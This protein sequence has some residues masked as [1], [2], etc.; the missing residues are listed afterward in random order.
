MARKPLI[1]E[2]QEGTG[3]IVPVSHKLNHDGYFRK[4]FAD[5]L[6]MYHVYV[7]EQ[8]HGKLPEGYEVHHKCGNRACC[9]IEHLE[10][11][12]GHEHTVL[13][14]HERYLNRYLEAKKYWD[15]THCTG[16]ALGEKFG[17]SFSTGC[18]WIRQW[19]SGCVETIPKG[20]R[21]KGGTPLVPEKRDTVPTIVAGRFVVL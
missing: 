2:E 11:I 1:F 20:S 17:V 12:E 21:A 15:E 19:N 6:V 4:R 8:H 5:S 14:N 3:C 9:N 18:K 16:T 13:G 7:W 10:A